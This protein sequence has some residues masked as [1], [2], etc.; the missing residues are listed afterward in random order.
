MLALLLVSCSS[1]VALGQEL[2]CNQSSTTCP[3]DVI[4]CEC[5]VTSDS[6]LLQW[7]ARDLQSEEDVVIETYSFLS[8]TGVPTY[9]GP[10]T[11]V[12]CNTTTSGSAITLTSKLTV[13]LIYIVGLGVTCRNGGSGN[14]N[15]TG[16]TLAGKLLYLS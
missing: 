2:S 9:S 1:I 6:P 14:S 4:Q 11:T 5:Q 15:T 7:L 13:T 3:G 10:Y 12:L 16:L 8:G